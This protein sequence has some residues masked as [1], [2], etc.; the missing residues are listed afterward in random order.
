MNRK[1]KLTLIT[2]QLYTLGGKTKHY[3]LAKIKHFD[4][5]VQIT[6]LTVKSKK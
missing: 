2:S 5:E 4:L 1:S 3:N 6:V